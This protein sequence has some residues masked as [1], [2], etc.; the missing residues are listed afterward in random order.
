MNNT[1]YRKVL[2]E[3][4]KKAS[5]RIEKMKPCFSSYSGEHSFEPFENFTM[6]KCVHCGFVR[7]KGMTSNTFKTRECQ[8]CEASKEAYLI[9][10]RAGYTLHKVMCPVCEKLWGV[11]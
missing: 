1:D 2:E 11:D 7:E 9:L 10:N 4:Y 6:I 5:W 8:G 3:E